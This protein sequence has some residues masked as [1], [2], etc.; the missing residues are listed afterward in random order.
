LAGAGGGAGVDDMELIVDVMSEAAVRI[1]D[2]GKL[3]TFTDDG[4]EE[5]I[6]AV[7]AANA[8]ANFEDLSVEEAVDTASSTA[9]EDPLVQMILEKERVAR[10]VGDC[11]GDGS[12]TVDEIVTGVNIALGNAEVDDCP[13]FDRNCDGT[14]TVDEI[15]TAVSNALNGCP[16]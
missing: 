1:L 10:C 12:V 4:I 15:V 3:E 2:F 9:Q 11:N 6:D 16:A 5:L 8:D 14:V 13:R 7:D